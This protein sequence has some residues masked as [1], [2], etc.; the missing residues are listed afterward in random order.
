MLEN[1]SG[2]K[3]PLIKS[4]QKHSDTSNT[5]ISNQNSNT[6]VNLNNTIENE[7]HKKSPSQD[8]TNEKQVD[9]R[10]EKIIE[11]YSAKGDNYNLANIFSKLFFYWAYRI[12]KVMFVIKM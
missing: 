11:D 10:A 12:I 4:D 9:I 5:D 1:D 8:L 2:K 3:E 7:I 6:T